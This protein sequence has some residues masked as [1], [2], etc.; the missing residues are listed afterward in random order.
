MNIFF[1]FVLCVDK[2]DIQN[3]IQ[4]CWYFTDLFD[5]T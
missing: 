5:Q 2:L 4:Q 1:M 3:H